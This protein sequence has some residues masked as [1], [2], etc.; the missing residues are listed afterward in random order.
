MIQPDRIVP[1]NRCE[2]RD[3]QYVLYWMQAAQ[4]AEYNHALEYAI[5]RANELKA[6]VLAAFGLTA[7]FP[8]ANARH[9]RFMLEGLQQ[10][11]KGLAGRGIRLVVRAETPPHCVARLAKKACLVVVDEGHLR[12]QRQWR[13]EVAEKITRPLIEVETNV[14]VPVETAAE[15]ENF[16]A[17][18]FR[19]RIRRQ[20]DTYLVPLRHRQ[21][22]FPSLGL[23]FESLDLRDIDK[24]IARLNLDRSVGPAPG[25]TGGSEQAK[26]RLDDFIGRKRD[27]YADQRNDPNLDGTSNLSPYLHFGQ[28]SPL[29]VALKVGQTPSPGNDAF[30]EELI[31]RRELSFNF[32]YYNHQYDSYECLPPWVRRTLDFHRRD[33]RQYVYSLEEFE[34]AKT[35]DP[36][37]NAA[38]KEMTL[39]GK[40]HGY[41]RMYW[42]K[43]ILEWSKSPEEGFRIALHLNNR[44]E[45]DG[46]DPNGYAGVAWCFGKHDR[47]WAERPVFGKVRYMNAAGLKRKFDP[48]AYVRKVERIESGR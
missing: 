1:L 11:E 42:G 12:V 34:T 33:R 27:G 20:L 32:V 28:I 44:Y 41:M 46:R 10:V 43:K 29:Q 40:M 3:G 35:H 18:T 13:A 17:G 22:R 36:Y 31:V 25:L 2:V 38:Q 6:P 45:L 47:A 7:D 5:D 21:V 24:V 8:E 15:R 48:D 19:P 30:L 23:S 9:Y 4:R 37:W 26:R 39:T 16:S 14:I